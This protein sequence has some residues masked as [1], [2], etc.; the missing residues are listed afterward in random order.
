MVCSEKN[1][2]V[3]AVAA[4]IFKAGGGTPEHPLWRETIAHGIESSLGPH[5]AR[6]L[7]DEKVCQ[8]REVRDAKY[9]HASAEDVR[10]SR[11][12]DL[13]NAVALHASVI[14]AACPQAVV[15]G[16]EDAMQ[17]PGRGKSKIPLSQAL[18]CR[19]SSRRVAQASLDCAQLVGNVKNI[20][21][22]REAIRNALEDLKKADLYADRC[23]SRHGAATKQARKRLKQDAR[24]LLVTLGSA[25]GV[26]KMLQAYP[27]GAL[28]SSLSATVI[29]DE[30]STVH[31]ALFV[32]AMVS[33][34]AKITNIVVVGD[35]RQ[36]DPYWPVKADKS[37]KQP[38]VVAGYLFDDA[39]E[40]AGGTIVRLTEQY[41]MP[42]PVMHILNEFFYSDFP[43]TFGKAKEASVS[44][45]PLGWVH[46]PTSALRRRSGSAVGQNREQRDETSRAEAT[47]A[48]YIARRAQENGHTVLVVTPYRQQR[49]LLK[50]SLGIGEEGPSSSATRQM[51]SH[52]DGSIFVCTVDGAQG[53][54]ADVVVVSLM[55]P[56][57]TRFLND[58][59]LCVLLSRAR[60]QMVIVG[61]RE[62]HRSCRTMPL[63]KLA[64]DSAATPARTM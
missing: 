12:G 40:V 43:L 13:D 49:D 52:P 46:V 62:Q 56:R 41:R 42:R 24:V 2:A 48:A 64:K 53:Q 44:S 29:C 14:A 16:D 21:S 54:E 4:A 23:V 27:S 37:S 55:K 50:R 30:A 8:V 47:E 38:P 10:K 17:A 9:E 35:D 20:A 19:W 58:K 11:E 36:L 1:L 63:R 3:D 34:V 60:T 28:D 39:L 61:D 7:L 32:S 5:A 18:Q 22:A 26:A 51:E 6:F 15:P 31:T 59:R 33:L 57:P 25:H 45:V